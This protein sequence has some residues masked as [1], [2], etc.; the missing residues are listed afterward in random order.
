MIRLEPATPAV[1]RAVVEG[2]PADVPHAPDWPHPD[3]ADALRPLAEHP[4]DTGPGTFL[5]LLDEVV[6]GDC[7]WLGPPDESGEVEIGYGLAR[8][9]RGRGVGREAV[10]QLLDWVAGQGATRVRAEVQPGNEPSLRLLAALGFERV[11]HRAGHEV[12][13]RDVGH[14]AARCDAPTT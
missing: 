7:G 8:S 10:R 9:A 6:V 1:A 13:A 5:V 11:E 3:T 4:D 2:R 12:L 14:G